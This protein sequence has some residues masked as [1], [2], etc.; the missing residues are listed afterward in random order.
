MQLVIVLNWYWVSR[1]SR[2]ERSRSVSMHLR[3]S[4]PSSPS[5]RYGEQSEDSH[6]WGGFS[7]QIVKGAVNAVKVFRGKTGRRGESRDGRRQR[8]NQCGGVPGGRGS[9]AVTVSASSAINVFRD[10]LIAGCQYS[11]SELLGLGRDSMERLGVRSTVRRGIEAGMH[12]GSIRNVVGMVLR[13]LANQVG[14]EG[15]R[16]A[17]S[18]SSTRWSGATW[19]RHGAGGRWGVLELGT[20]RNKLVVREVYSSGATPLA[21]NRALDGVE[22]KP[23]ETGSGS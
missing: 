13:S 12:C 6:W 14:E 7:M 1:R 5:S 23:W 21:R 15:R 18:K 11:Q 9:R 16:N 20:Y 19:E 10:R 4:R 8:V 22:W 17:V 3:D 2:M